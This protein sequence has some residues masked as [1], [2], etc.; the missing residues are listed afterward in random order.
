MEKRNAT[1]PHQNHH[2]APVSEY[3]S[4]NISFSYLAGIVNL[5][6]PKG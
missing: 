6:V 3:D 2:P 1:I 4:K 5:P